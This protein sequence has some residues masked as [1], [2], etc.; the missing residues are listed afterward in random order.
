MANWEEEVI[1]IL[2]SP[3]WAEKGDGTHILCLWFEPYTCVVLLS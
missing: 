3:V 2:R 1:I